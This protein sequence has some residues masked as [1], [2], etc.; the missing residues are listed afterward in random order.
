MGPQLAAHS[1]EA[2]LFT[3]HQQT[4]KETMCIQSLPVY[5]FL[6]HCGGKYKCKEFCMRSE[7]SA[8]GCTSLPYNFHD[9]ASTAIA[10]VASGQFFGS[11]SRFL[12]IIDHILGDF[13]LPVLIID[14][15]EE[16]KGVEPDKDTEVL[17]TGFHFS[18]VTLGEPIS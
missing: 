7:G 15:G 17:V 16:A 11:H 14:A 10:Q 13:L 3:A 8:V 9:F 5:G 18:P 2:K 1:S 12:E 6:E 4:L